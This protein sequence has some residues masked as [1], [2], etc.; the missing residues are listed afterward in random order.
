MIRNITCIILLFGIAYGQPS[1]DILGSY[2]GI[3]YIDTSY[4]NVYEVS[5]YV[6][7]IVDGDTFYVKITT[8][9][10]RTQ[11]GSI[12]KV[13][14]ADIDC[15]ETRGSKANAEGREAKEFAEN[16]LLN[17]SI[18][19]D[20]DDKTGKDRFGRWIAVCYLNGRN[21]NK[22]LI[23]KSLAIAKDYKNNEF[24]PNNW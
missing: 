6:T 4:E 21:F 13:R 15:P 20:L 12:I 5:G 14:L 11:V 18:W 23:Q 17:Q 10:S 24:D 1:I 19:L 3:G 16:Q 2:M 8:N 22:L 7:D 9:D